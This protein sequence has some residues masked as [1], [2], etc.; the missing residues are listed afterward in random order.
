MKLSNCFKV[1]SEILLMIFDE[2]KKTYYAHLSHDKKEKETLFEHSKLVSDYCLLLIDTHGIELVI[3]SLIRKLTQNLPIKNC[4]E[5]ECLFKESFIAAIIYHDLGKVNPN[6]QVLK[7]ENELFFPEKNF[8]IQSYHSFLGSYLF[9]SIYLK[10]TF[11][12]ENF[13]VEEKLLLYFIVFLFSSSIAK[14]HNSTIDL[15]F[16]LDEQ[17]V[18]D[19]FSFLKTYSIQFDKDFGKNFFLNAVNIYEGFNILVQDKLEVYF[20]LFATTKLLY[21]LLT[22]SDFYA[23]NEFMTKIKINEFGTLSRTEK[24]KIIKQFKTVKPYNKDLYSKLEHYESIPFEKLTKRNTQNLNILRQKLTAELIS[25]LREHSDNKCFYLEAPTGSGKTNLSLAF[26]TELMNIDSSLNKVF[27]IFPYTTLITQTFE[28][29]KET[30]DMD[31]N[32]II[33]LHSKS[34]FHEKVDGT[35]GSDKQLYIDNLFVNYPI[36]LMS[37]IHFFNILKGNEKE[38]NYLLH[39]LCNSIVIIDEIQ[40][41][42]PEHWDKIVYFLAN[43]AQ[44]FNIRILIMSATLPKID[45]LHPELNGSF[46]S[47]ISNRDQYFLNQNFTGRVSFN[48]TWAEKKRP[49]NKEE[50]EIYLIELSN[51]LFEKAEHYA[52]LNSQ[53]VYVLIEFITKK[54]AASFFNLLNNDSHYKDYKILLLSG[55]ILEFRR[56]QIINSIKEQTYSKV[57]LVSTQVVEAG[58]DIDMDIGFKDRS[59][60]DSD[61]QLAGRINRNASKDNCFVYMF[62]CDKTSTIYGSDFRYKVQQTNKEILDNFKE[63]LVK[64]RFHALYEKVFEQKSKSMRNIFHADNSYYQHFKNFNFSKLHSEFKLI[65]DND[66][67]QL[68][69]PIWIPISYFDNIPNLE[70]MGVLTED[71]E[72]VDGIKVFEYYEKIINLKFDDFSMKKIELKKVG[73]ILSQFSISVNRKQLENIA[74]MLHPDKSNYGFQYLLNWNLCYFPE[75]GFDSKKVDTSYLI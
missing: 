1:Y 52:S 57:I 42:N 38:S 20:N 54:T 24:E 48:F 62:D 17:Q 21:S 70:K 63:I 45:M 71:K 37:H 14:H 28:S 13:S 19:C 30:L 29:I 12:N 72:Y 15:S 66:S 41:Y 47:L 74:D 60:L 49:V 26:A 23:T 18:D 53:K 35:Y 4:D 8:S 5:F 59:L 22:A 67:Q 56:K 3:D 6:F 44:L 16:E 46:I 75:S 32:S 9:A 31:N 69:I 65:E 39:R 34:G 10:K 61:E 64:K 68:F 27:Y 33:Q 50:K 2:L 73:N 43:Y 11:E 25:N 55:D 7:M 51:F 36:A 58:A 40:T